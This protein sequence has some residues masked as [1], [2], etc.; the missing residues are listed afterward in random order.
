[1]GLLDSLKGIL[2]VK[3]VNI[4]D[5]N[6][7]A[8]HNRQKAPPIAAKPDPLDNIEITEEY[9]NVLALIESKAPIIFVSGKAGTGKTTLIH[10][11][12]H[13]LNKNIV[14]VAPT[15]VA[16]LNVKGSTIHSYF[17]LPPRV[18]EDGDIKLV[19]DRNLYTKL[20]LLIVDEISMVRA[21]L[22]DAMDKFLR[23]NGAH[24]NKPFGGAQLLLVGD[25]F[26]LPPVVTSSEESI[27]FSRKYTSPFFFS[28]NSLNNCEMKALELH[29]VFR[30]SDH[31]FTELLNKIRVAEELDETLPLINE[32]YAETDNQV[33]TLT[34]TNASADRINAAEINKLPGEPRIFNGAIAGKFSVNDVRLPAPLN[35]SLKL[36]AQVMFTKNDGNKRWVNGSVGKIVSFKNNSI[37]VE[38]LTDHPGS[39]HDVQKVVWKSFKYKYDYEEEKI[40]TEEAGSYTQYPLMLAWAVTIHKSQGKTLERVRVDLGNGAFAP[41]QVYV[42]LSRCRSLADIS[43]ARPILKKDVKC[44]ESIKEFYHALAGDQYTAPHQETGDYEPSP[45][46]QNCVPDDDYDNCSETIL[47]PDSCNDT[48]IAHCSNCDDLIVGYDNI[49]QCES[50][51]S[52]YCSDCERECLFYDEPNNSIVCINCSDQY[53]DEKEDN[54]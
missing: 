7:Q 43:L 6:R 18:I 9:R 21:D 2:G 3:S 5:L 25:L 50:C 32:R 20:D 17:R 29:K 54:D 51:D 16:A 40:K 15:G 39:I 41:G 4:G 26:Q 37:Q 42:A 24:K 49:H 33:L 11:V 13:S 35:L 52:I 46:E 19:K 48:S 1:M 30:Q 10:Y 45:A 14:V 31:N 38:L 47:I 34:C 27:L 53:E 23:K 28:A 8:T 12:R 36:G 44:D 22:V